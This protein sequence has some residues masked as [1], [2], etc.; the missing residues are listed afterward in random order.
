[1]TVTQLKSLEQANH[2]LE[3]IHVQGYDNVRAMLTALECIRSIFYEQMNDVET[4]E[5]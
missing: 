4:K 1:M 3:N 5:N 2:A